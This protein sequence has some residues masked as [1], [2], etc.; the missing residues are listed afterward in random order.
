M[1]R[2]LLFTFA[3]L[4]A[5]ASAQ[6]VQSIT[7]DGINDFDLANLVEADGGDTEHAELDI[8]NVYLT[9]DANNLYLGYD[10]D[11]GS[12]G[13]IQLGVAID[14]GTA[15]GGISDPWARK[16][17]WSQAALKP[18]FYFYINVDNGWQEG[19]RWNPGPGAWDRF[20][21]GVGSLGVIMDT[22]F[23]EYAIPL[24]TLGVESGDAIHVEVWVTQDGGTKGPLDAAANDAVQL[25]TPDGT[26]F[27]VSMPVPMTEYLAYTIL[28]ATDNEPPTLLSAGME[29]DD[30]VVVRFSEAVGDGAEDPAN[31][32]LAGATV[33]DAVRDGTQLDLVRLT[34][35]SALPVSADLYTVAVS[36]V[37]DLAGNE[38]A[39]G[40][41]ADFL[42]KTVTFR[43]R[44]SRYLAEASDPPDGFTVE[45]GV[46]PLT[47]ALCDGAEMTDLGDG[48]YEWSGR[49]SAPGDG[50]GGASLAFEWKFVHNCTTYESLPGNR[51]HTVTLDGHDT[52]LIDVW[53]DDEDPSLFTAGPVDVIFT[54]DMNDV[55]PA[56]TD[57]VAIAGNVAP[58]D[59]AWPPSV[60]MTDD[61]E[62]QDETAGDLIYTTVVSFPA[63]SRKDVT[64]KFRL[65]GEY[66]CFGQGDRDVYLND[67]EFDVIGG[68]LGPLVLPLYVWDYCTVT[69]GSVEVVFR[70]DASN[71][72][73]GGRTFA[74]NGTETPGDPPAFSW[75]IPSLNPMADDGIAP[76]ETAGDGV[77]S[78]AVVFPVGS[79]LFTEYKYL[80][81]DEYE[82]FFG[83]RGFG[84]DPWNHDATGNPQVLPVDELFTPVGVDDVPAAALAD[85]V[86]WPNPFN[87]STDI[88]FTVH[89]AGAGS[90]RVFDVQGRVVRTLFV[91]DFA[92]GPQQFT[93]DGRDDAGDGVAS[94]VYL[95]RL[96]VADEV[97]SRKMMLLK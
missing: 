84:L 94:G 77:Y 8:G 39:A 40:A 3:L 28:D 35:A 81:D 55:G 80:V 11:E 56:P 34:L 78:V 89:R 72:P 62:G 26:T 17:E 54:V 92:T 63:G 43:G 32:T 57:T 15:I 87:P 83:N 53:W 1:R 93:W 73:Q 76:D 68:E 24:T 18:D 48:V 69:F 5:G 74:V 2:A 22:G 16:L 6:V 95:Y 13:Q 20:A 52:D 70:L 36:N 45:G 67:E 19:F 96:E 51:T 85:L 50:D 4:A 41:M 31:Y 90:L 25:S 82:G 71:T 9:N 14:V 79:N 91:G 97:G 88:R 44:M 60:V 37:R 49:F 58:L 59:Q 7:I 66:E 86:N 75:D 46:W 21:Q 42:W 29:A 47:W 23:R 64:Y 27:D 10:H 38:I 12:W 61:G 33:T 65:N 30:T